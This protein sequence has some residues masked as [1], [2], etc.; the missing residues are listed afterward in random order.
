MF[1]FE[2][3]I[4]GENDI[5]KAWQYYSDVN[6]W[7]EFDQGMDHVVINGPFEDEQTGTI[8]LKNTQT[9]DFTLKNVKTNE[10]YEMHASRGP[11]AITY[12]YH[13]SNE[14]ITHSLHIEGGTDKQMN[15]FGN[16]IASKIPA[17]MEMLYNLIKA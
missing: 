1:D 8:Y 6:K 9:L 16:K 13:V 2:H 7:P 3:T 10:G 12:G 4:D 17:N 14:K 15:G 5:Q 11:M